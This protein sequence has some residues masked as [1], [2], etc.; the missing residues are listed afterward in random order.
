MAF[1]SKMNISSTSDQDKCTLSGFTDLNPLRVVSFKSQRT[2]GR[3]G[4]L[5]VNE[6]RAFF[7]SARSLACSFITRLEVEKLDLCS[8]K[9]KPTRTLKP[10]YISKDVVEL[11]GVT[12][13]L[14]PER[15]AK[16]N[17]ITNTINWLQC[18]AIVSCAKPTR[19]FPIS[20]YHCTWGGRNPLP[21]LGVVSVQ[22]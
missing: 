3:L 20:I 8:A 19:L 15:V 17:E 13:S 7:D 10:L 6:P 18:V 21:L 9:L 22:L 2:Q 14:S 16:L 4:F 12:T 1:V 11:F 5:E